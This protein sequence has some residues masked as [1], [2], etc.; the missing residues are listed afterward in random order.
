MA[1]T[2]VRPAR[3]RVNCQSPGVQGTVTV[4]IVSQ[5]DHSGQE[6]VYDRPPVMVNCLP[7]RSTVTSSRGHCYE[8]PAG[9]DHWHHHDNAAASCTARLCV[10][11]ALKAAASGWARRPEVRL[12]GLSPA[13]GPAAVTAAHHRGDSGPQ[14]RGRQ[15]QWRPEASSPTSRDSSQLS[16]RG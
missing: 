16:S 11:E 7:R 2:S 6:P 3:I 13:P 5:V 8:S 1:L 14:G 4:M 10:S 9:R 15:A 12:L